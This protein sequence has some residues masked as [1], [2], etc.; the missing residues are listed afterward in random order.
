TDITSH[1][2]LYSSTA[3]PAQG[4]STGGTVPAAALRD[5]PAFAPDERSAEAPAAP[6]PEEEHGSPAIHISFIGGT[7]AKDLANVLNRLATQP[8]LLPADNVTLGPG[9][10]PTKALKARGVPVAGREFD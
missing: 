6:A 1:A 10:N 8:R 4:G 5:A 9:Y 3:S 7:V 2:T